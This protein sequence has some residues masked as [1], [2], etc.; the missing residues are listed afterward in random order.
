M[1]RGALTAPYES[2]SSQRRFRNRGARVSPNEA[3]PDAYESPPPHRRSRHTGSTALRSESP[4]EMYRSPPPQG[5]S[6][7]PDITATPS[8]PKLE[9]F[10]SPP[11]QR[12]SRHQGT[13]TTKSGHQTDTF[14]VS[15]SQRCR[16]RDPT[17]LRSESPMNPH[18]APP[19]RRSRHTATTSESTFDTYGSPPRRRSPQRGGMSTPSESP[20][21]TYGPPLP[22]RRSPLRGAYGSPSPRR[23]S[24]LRG[25]SAKPIES[26]NLLLSNATD[27]GSEV[28][29][30]I[31][32]EYSSPEVKQRVKA[33]RKLRQEQMSKPPLVSKQPQLPLESS[34][35]PDEDAVEVISDDNG[36]TPVTPGNKP[37]TRKRLTHKG[38]DQSCQ[39][40]STPSTQ[41]PSPTGD[42]SLDPNTQLHSH[43]RTAGPDAISPHSPPNPISPQGA[44][45]KP[46]NRSAPQAS[47][48][49]Q[50]WPNGTR[51]TGTG[52]AD[53]GASSSRPPSPRDVAS[54]AFSS[55]CASLEVSRSSAGYVRKV[56]RLLESHNNQRTPH[57]HEVSSRGSSPNSHS[58]VNS[59]KR[60]GGHSSAPTKAPHYPHVD[61]VVT[62]RSKDS[63][64]GSRHPGE[65]R[66]PSIRQRTTQSRCG[67]PGQ[68]KGSLGDG[69]K[70]PSP[71]ATTSSSHVTR[72]SQRHTASDGIDSS[73]SSLYV[74]P[75][76]TSDAN[77]RPK[78]SRALRDR[79]MTRYPAEGRLTRLGEVDK[80]RG[81]SDKQESWK[82][83]RGKEKDNK[84]DT[85]ASQLHQQQ[86]L[87]NLRQQVQ[88]QQQALLQLQA[89]QFSL[90]THV[91]HLQYVVPTESQAP[92]VWLPATAVLP[93]GQHGTG[94]I[95][96]SST[97]K[98]VRASAALKPSTDNASQASSR[99]AVS[100]SAVATP[101]P[102]Q[103]ASSRHPSTAATSSIHTHCSQPSKAIRLVTPS[104]SGPAPLS[105]SQPS[106]N[107]TVS[108]STNP[109]H[110][111][112]RRP[113]IPSPPLAPPSYS[114][115]DTTV[116]Q[117]PASTSTIPVNCSSPVVT[118]PHRARFPTSHNTGTNHTTALKRTCMPPI[119][120]PLGSR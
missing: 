97:G 54:N 119:T 48:P 40:P 52:T 50:S 30:I 117:S 66:S 34:L 90:G 69:V 107:L 67:A 112:S 43:K 44:T 22:R 55:S 91:H 96:P 60:R 29:E 87:Q 2:P 95:A 73:L 21:E 64:R 36:V 118:S 42:D 102:S 113:P 80:V 72:G 11:L 111:V 37:P 84:I 3:Q 20:I 61:H 108:Q 71:V 81:R 105:S 16:P 39:Q 68:V 101:A 49:H 45:P 98:V 100:S 7:H 8:G 25:A 83:S 106:V 47:R 35:R 85:I 38:A 76:S 18:N 15:P 62:R 31:E 28:G 82:I 92:G 33:K 27:K 53:T 89:H 63:P 74:S 14:D 5:R 99:W 94:Y 115:P 56:E 78:M 19:Q 46:A 116:R 58:Q 79:G 13:I 41:A 23:R 114:H 77:S 120:Q 103:P 110:V 17:A 51:S 10:D 75:V 109:S 24:P 104:I 6:R 12:R 93:A 4:T 32:G 26:S 70:I 59:V 57:R 88:Q 86:E 65:S 1:D 9:S